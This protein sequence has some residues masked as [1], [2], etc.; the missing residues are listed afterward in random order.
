LDF[1][2]I[3]WTIVYAGFTPG[4]SRVNYDFNHFCHP[5]RH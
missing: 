4:T 1:V 3:G 5:T 2:D